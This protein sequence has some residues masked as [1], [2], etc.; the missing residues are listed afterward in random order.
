MEEDGR[1]REYLYPGQHAPAKGEGTTPLEHSKD[2]TDSLSL[3]TS[4]S[5]FGKG[6]RKQFSV[7]GRRKGRH[8]NAA[9]E[10][11]MFS[12]ADVFVLLMV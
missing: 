7:L 4:L 10:T 9:E 11:S 3:I 2:M 12:K 8:V 6:E 1:E 5:G